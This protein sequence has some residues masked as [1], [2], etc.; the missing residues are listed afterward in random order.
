MTSV[1]RPSTATGM[2]ILFIATKAPFPKS[3]GGRLLMWNTLRE[4]FARGHQ[5][6]FVAPDL[7]ATRQGAVDQ[8]AQFCR[9]RLVPC[10]PGRLLPSAIRAQLTRQPLSVLRHTHKALQ[11]VIREELDQ[12][13][14]DIIHAEQVQSIFNVPSG[15]GRPPIILRAQNVESRLWRMVGG[16][17]PRFGW[18]ARGEARKMAAAE[19]RAV[20]LA[21]TTVA[22]THRDGEGLAGGRGMRASRI[23]IIP[24][25][26]PSDLPTGSEEL[27]GAPPLLLLGGGWLP[28]R[29]SISWFFDSIWD[30]VRRENPKAHAHVFGVD[31]GPSTPGTSWHPSPSDSRHIFCSGTILVVPLRIASGI[32]MKIIESWARGIPVVATPEA[33]RGLE[34]GDG[35]ELLLARDG[36]EFAN[37]IRRL[38]E[39]AGLRK[40]LTEAGRKMVATRHDPARIVTLL[41]ETYQAAQ[42]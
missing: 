23:H 39:E 21:S 16:V 29:D 24:P 33:V 40:Q 30:D 25:P 5:V 19:A 8:I 4:L 3:D 17:R 18:I 38:N 41:E 7:G 26:F 1:C 15:A 2:R 28:N 13:E 22:L 32:R 20:R 11:Q 37:A 10:R 34:A 31:A 27:P 42:R 35:H 9:P 12:H 36:H 6:T 14:Y